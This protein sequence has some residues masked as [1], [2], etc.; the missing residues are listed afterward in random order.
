MNYITSIVASS[1]LSKISKPITDKILVPF[2]NIIHPISNVLYSPFKQL[3]IL[4]T[5]VYLSKL[6]YIQV[7]NNG[8]SF[9]IQKS[10]SNSFIQYI[11]GD[12][13]INYLGNYIAYLNNL[14]ILDISIIEQIEDSIIYYD[15]EYIYSLVNC[16]INKADYSIDFRYK[17]DE[18]IILLSVLRNQLDDYNFE[19][20]LLKNKTKLIWDIKKALFGINSNGYLY[21]KIDWDNIVIHNNNF[22]LIVDDNIK[23]PLIENTINSDWFDFIIIYNNNILNDDNKLEYCEESL[24]S[25]IEYNL[26]NIYTLDNIKI[27]NQ[28]NVNEL[29]FLMGHME[30]SDDDN[31]IVMNF[32][33]D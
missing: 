23:Q 7:E 4:K 33:N 13:I 28:Y 11:K 27:Q 17:N 16:I 32:I 24:Q 30:E 3:S 1:I 29:N 31:D 19:L 14:I 26:N 2:T 25:F 12:E 9:L 5:I 18:N 8:K 10:S 6:N 15:Y 22:K 21:G 20:F